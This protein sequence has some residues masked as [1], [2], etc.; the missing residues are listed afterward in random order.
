M[1]C[2][3]LQQLYGPY[4]GYR[5]LTM[6]LETLHWLWRPCFGFRDLTMALEATN[7]STVRTVLRLSVHGGHVSLEVA[8]ALERLGAELA[9]VGLKIL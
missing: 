7:L 2:E 3:T 9:G 1:A 6:A 5:D 4:N 8:F